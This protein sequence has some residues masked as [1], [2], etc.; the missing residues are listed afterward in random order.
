M[1]SKTLGCRYCGRD[2]FAGQRG[3]T[4][5]QQ[6]S[7]ICS[8]LLANDLETDLGYQTAQDGLSYS[9]VSSL[10]HRKRS[11]TSAELDDCQQPS[12]TTLLN[13]KLAR[14]T[15]EASHT[16]EDE[17]EDENYQTAREDNYAVQPNEGQ[18]E[19]DD[20]G[21]Y[22]S[23]GS[24][25][26]EDAVDND[27]AKVERQCALRDE[28]RAY[29]D[30]AFKNYAPFT[31]DETV[32][33]RCMHVLR[34]TKAPLA[35][36]D[37]I[38]EWHLKET[39]AIARHE[40][41]GKTRK[42]LTR[43]RVFKKL[44]KR[45]NV[46]P[47]LY[48]ITKRRTL[49]SSKSTVNIICS[50]A[51]ALVTSILT[52]PRLEDKDY[53]FF[54][55]D[56]FKPPPAHLDY[57]ADINTG[58]T[59]TE[60]YK[61]TIT[62]PS[63]QM[64]IMLPCY[65][66]GATTG[67]YSNLPIVQFK[68]TLGILNQKARDQEIFWRVLGTVPNVEVA[69][70]RG[71]RIM[72]NSGHADG[73]MAHQDV[74]EQ[75]GS[76]K[77]GK[78]VH[79]STDYH[80]MLSVIFESL[81]QLQKDTMIIDFNYK[82]KAYKDIQAFFFVPH[83]KADN[84]EADKLCAKYGSRSGNV[85]HLCR[86]CHCPTEF[87]ARATAKYRLKTQTEIKKLV[88]NKEL[89]ALKAMSQHHRFTNA[90]YEVKFG[91]HSDTGI[92]GACPID[93]LHTILLGLFLRVRDCFFVQVGA[94]SDTTKDLDAL[95]MEY[96]ELYARH[97]ERNMPKTK[98]SKGITGGKIMAKEYEGV[99]L[100]LATIVRC[101][102]GRRLLKSARSKK[103]KEDD[104]IQDWALLLE[105]LL[106]WIEWL[107]CTRLKKKH[108]KA[109][110]WKHRYLMFLIKRVIRRT[111]GMGMKFPKFH[112]LLHIT[113]DLLNHGN[114]A[115]IDTGTNETGHKPTKRAA[116]LTQKNPFLFDIQTAT[117]L[118]EAFL[119]DLAMNELDGRPLW[120]Y[121]GGY[122]PRH[123]KEEAT[124][125][126][127]T[128]GSKFECKY[129]EETEETTLYVANK[130]AADTG[131]F[132]ETDL[133]DFVDELQDEVARYT[134]DP[135]LVRTE[136][137][138]NGEIFRAHARYRGSVWRDWVEINWGDEV[139]KLPAKLWGFVDLTM[140]PQNNGIR[141]AGLDGL[142]PAVYAIVESASYSTDQ[143]AIDMSDIFVPVTKEVGNIAGGSVT[144]LKFYLADVEA[145]SAPMVV[146]PDIGGDP[147]AYFYVKN[148]LCWREDFEA[149][150]ETPAHESTFTMSDDEESDSDIDEEDTPKERKRRGVEQRENDEDDFIL[151]AFEDCS[152]DEAVLEENAV[153][154]D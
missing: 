55:D 143:A 128:G 48:N 34:K 93:M 20:V 110:E 33:I 2:N 114:A 102:K 45:Y 15:R 30:N 31:K 68:L 104:L 149:W 100:L 106:G 141:I 80:Y 103:F 70:S 74:L 139:G 112:Q 57:V 136:H 119:L 67:Q 148:R 147:N 11:A 142:A 94:S 125:D 41:L 133:I 38:M 1:A 69:R 10:R 153:V 99:M 29:T 121:L 84:E 47:D 72:L 24:E 92:H 127:T 39:K 135:V 151:G 14:V 7:A 134:E 46:N 75:E 35:T 137:K 146:I 115:A 120:H 98:F 124:A 52:D 22:G 71:R 9:V 73:I 36:Y 4:Q 61:K 109:S 123:A 152:G 12:K 91:L 79:N 108:V 28:F 77:E 122:T 59:Y 43:K 89:A 129:N 145:F 154:S 13:Q 19:D 26:I 53:L 97:S 50:D 76:R 132:V 44:L 64:L 82:G 16:Q 105:T 37:D 101:S 18:S 88:D 83:V 140:I 63:K 49:P 8:R 21:Y 78:E 58:L 17:S 138:R 111:E 42:F 150:L 40:T 126:P 113:Q 27:A 118:L 32:A 81:V 23:D 95:A 60:T 96:G 62:D 90:F 85:S 107:K 130:V 3:L 25:E 87:T 116:L 51:R 117:R 86:Q 131:M 65:I 5:H 66:D 54:D 6:K 56:P 144:K